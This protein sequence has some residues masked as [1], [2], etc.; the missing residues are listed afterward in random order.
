MRKLDL[1]EQKLEL[2]K[3][4]LTQ[5][6]LEVRAGNMNEA[7]SPIMNALAEIALVTASPKRVISDEDGDEWVVTAADAADAEAAE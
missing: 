7:I 2:Q 4:E 6:A 5:D 1:E 3:R